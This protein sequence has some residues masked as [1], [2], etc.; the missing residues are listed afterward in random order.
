M[1][2]NVDV[3]KV[4]K[5]KNKEIYL[6]KLNIDIDNN[7]EILSITIGNIMNLLTDE[8]RLKLTDFLSS[9][10]QAVIL[11][12][13]VT[14]Q[15]QL[16]DKLIEL[17]QNRSLNLKENVM[18]IDNIDYNEVIN[19]ISGSIMNEIEKYYFENVKIL[20]ENLKID[21]NTRVQDY[22]N[23]NFYERICTKIQE[24]LKNMDVILKNAY[25]EGE[26]KFEDLNAKTLNLV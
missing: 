14:F 20:N 19:S 10:S 7:T 8:L 11:Q 21:S 15:K 18:N 26:A 17:I 25:K 13:V 5:E 23:N 4:L 12:Q 2:N 24:A 22:L 16:S 1:N 3:S 6:N 9:T